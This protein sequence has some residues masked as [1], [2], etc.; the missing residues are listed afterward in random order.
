[1]RKKNSTFGVNAMFRIVAMTLIFSL[2][3]QVGLAE[4]TVTTV[5]ER[6]TTTREKQ[7]Q[8]EV[9]PDDFEQV[10]AIFVAN[11][12]GKAFNDEVMFVE[13]LIVSQVSDLGFVT[14]S[15]EVVTDALS[16]YGGGKSDAATELDKR[17]LENT[18]ALALARNLGASHIIS[19]SI[20]SFARNKKQF[21]DTDGSYGGISTDVSQYVLRVPYKIL[22]ATR[23]GSLTAD[24][25]KVSKTIRQT[26]GLVIEEGDLL[27]DLLDEASQQI[28]SSLEKRIKQGRIKDSA[29]L[30][31]RVDL[32]VHCGMTDLSI[33]DVKEQ[34]DGSYQIVANAY[35]LEPMSVTV[36]IDG[37]VVGTAPGTFPVRLGISKIRLSR[38]GFK[39]WARTIN[40][41]DGQ[42]LNVSLQMDEAGYDRWRENISFLQNQKDG[43]VITEAQAE[44]IRAKAKMFEQSGMRIDY[45][46]DADK[47]PDVEINEK[48]LIR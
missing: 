4:E 25:I 5:V 18:S 41:Y 48:S 36:E 24:T 35:K 26:D 28:A 22:D 15:R 21:R 42:V 46:I 39:E 37:M 3:W 16:G 43:A 14:L 2:A 7:E 9:I 27:N 13:D 11:R 23:G 10:A 19:V 34:E 44:L 30:A 12:A 32:T 17:L 38:E 20:G 29:Q 6:I 8:K 45:R 40:V 33:P 31:E 1:M 47:A